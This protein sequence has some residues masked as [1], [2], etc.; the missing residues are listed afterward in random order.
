MAKDNRKV[1]YDLERKRV[2]LPATMIALLVLIAV[3]NEAI[4]SNRGTDSDSQKRTIAAAQKWLGDSEASRQWEQNLAHN[5]SDREPRDVASLGRSPSAFDQLRYGFL[6]GKYAVQL[7]DG[8]LREIS[9]VENSSDRPRYIDD[10]K[11]FLKEQ[12]ALLGVEFDEIVGQDKTNRGNLVVEKLDLKA[13]DGR[14][15]ASVEYVTDEFGRFRELK[16][17]PHQ[18]IVQ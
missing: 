5:L 8:K 15:P 1:R 17:T 13:A 12:K 2:A 4:N 11:A 10:I 16:I 6:E 14:T 7:V 3:G 9:F 18:S